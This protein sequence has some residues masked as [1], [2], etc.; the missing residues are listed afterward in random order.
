MLPP[1]PPI[2]RLQV[3]SRA[4]R[5]Q[6]K[7]AGLNQWASADPD[8]IG[9]GLAKNPQFSSAD[10]LLRRR[11]RAVPDEQLHWSYLAPTASGHTLR[12]LLGLT[13]F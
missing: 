11:C 13:F 1:C 12:K 6:R 3:D 5:A 9:G 4:S 7:P 2:S 8:E 10:P